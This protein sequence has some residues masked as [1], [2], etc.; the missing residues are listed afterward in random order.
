MKL[1]NYEDFLNEAKKIKTPNS[2]QV[3]LRVPTNLSE[4]I[5]S[6]STDYANELEY[7]LVDPQG[8]V[9]DIVSVIVQSYLD[10]IPPRGMDMLEIFDDWADSE[11]DSSN[12]FYEKIVKRYSKSW[13]PTMKQSK[14]YGL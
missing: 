6:R 11:A 13:T 7:T 4:T 3:E 14:K 1:S 2:I 5:V 9:T 8:L 12:S 10:D